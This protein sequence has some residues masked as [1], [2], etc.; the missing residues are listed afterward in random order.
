MV[1]TSPEHA[2]EAV[3]VCY[4]HSH[5]GGGDPRGDPLSQHILRCTR[6]TLGRNMHRLGKNMH[7]TAAPEQRLHHP[8]VTAGEPLVDVKYLHYTDTGRCCTIATNKT[9]I[10]HQS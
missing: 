8:R 6:Y 10:P 9:T 5:T 1:F 7:Q 3:R 2:G 4:Q